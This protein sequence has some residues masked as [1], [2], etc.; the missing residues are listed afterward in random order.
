MNPPV[1]GPTLLVVDDDATVRFS[2]SF[3]LDQDGYN[4]IT[5]SGGHEA[6]E[7]YRER[8][9]E[10]A[11][12]LLDIQMPELNGLEVLAH[13]REINSAVRAIVMSGYAEQLM[14]GEYHHL[15]VAFLSKP[16]A[17][18]SLLGVLAVAGVVP[19]NLS[20]RCSRCRFLL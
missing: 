15:G 12:V 8:W 18:E 16:F 3:L 7:L 9:G 2:L 10:I 19:A 5:A 17:I 6:I 11:I 1:S 14:S 13:L 4:V 20:A